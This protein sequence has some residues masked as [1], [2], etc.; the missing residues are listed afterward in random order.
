MLRHGLFLGAERAFWSLEG[1]YVT[2]AGY[3][4]GHTPNP[5]YNEV[6]TGRTAHAEVV[7]VVHDPKVLPL[8]SLLKL[9]GRGMTPPK[10]CARAMMWARSTGR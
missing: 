9:F 1:V 3:A 6:C 2:A 5:T 7:L 8:A 10:A 4:G